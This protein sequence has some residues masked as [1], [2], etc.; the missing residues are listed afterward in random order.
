MRKLSPLVW[1]IMKNKERLK[2]LIAIVFSS[3]TSQ[4]RR[5]STGSKP[6]PPQHQQQ[7]PASKF[8]VLRPP[9]MSPVTCSIHCPQATNFPELSCVSCHSLFHPKCVGLVDGVNYLDYEFYCFACTPPAGK[10]NNEPPFKK[11]PLVS[12]Q[13]TGRHKR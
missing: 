7:Q 12:G 13:V 2:K 9:R 1:F 10:E 11:T 6:P 3:A 4:P 8:R 5:Q